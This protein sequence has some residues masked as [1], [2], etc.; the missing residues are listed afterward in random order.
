MGDLGSAVLHPA[1]ALTESLPTYDH[2]LTEGSPDHHESEGFYLSELFAEPP[3]LTKSFPIHVPRTTEQ[4]KQRSRRC[5]TCGVASAPELHH[6]VHRCKHCNNTFSW[7]LAEQTNSEA[8]AGP[9][10]PR[11]TSASTAAQDKPF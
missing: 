5:P 6:P 11:A 4:A 1:A 9:S 8:D 3:L 7:N 10:S 2:A